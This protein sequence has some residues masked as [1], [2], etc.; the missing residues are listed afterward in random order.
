MTIWSFN[1]QNWPNQTIYK[2][3]CS[4]QH[5]CRGDSPTPRSV[6]CPRD[7]LRPV[8]VRGCAEGEQKLTALR[9][10]IAGSCWI[11]WNHLYI[12]CEPIFHEVTVPTKHETKSW[13]IT[14]S[15]NST[16]LNFDETLKIFNPLKI[17]LYTD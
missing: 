4:K 8:M 5:G 17:S 9:R 14:H 7:P 13:F 2:W 11:L 1:F 15:R 10:I 3:T 12:S 16:K 6:E